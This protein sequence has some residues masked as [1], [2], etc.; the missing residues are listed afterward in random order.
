MQLVKREISDKLI[1]IYLVQLMKE[2]FRFSAAIKNKVESLL[3]ELNTISINRLSFYQIKN[4]LG[5]YF[6]D[7]VYYFSTREMDL[8]LENFDLSLFI[9]SDNKVSTPRIFSNIKQESTDAGGLLIMELYNVQLYELY[10]KDGQYFVQACSDLELGENG[11]IYFRLNSSIFWEKGQVKRRFESTILDDSFDYS[12]FPYIYDRDSKSEDVLLGDQHINEQIITPSHFEN[13][14]AQNPD[15]LRRLVPLFEN[16]M[17][18]AKIAV[19]HNPLLFSLLTITLRAN[20]N[21]VVSVMRESANPKIIFNFLGDY[22]RQDPAIREIVSLEETAED[23][24][25]NDDDDLPF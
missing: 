1:R 12:L 18:L 10:S 4:I 15:S 22:L 21:F 7:A 13:N 9:F 17:E 2:E 11:Q 19:R 8:W 20:R 16:N 6:V 3:G 24:S 5:D 14:A 23:T 25:D